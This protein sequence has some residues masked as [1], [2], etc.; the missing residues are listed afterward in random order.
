MGTALLTTLVW[1]V[2]VWLIVR[3]V[4]ALYRD[5]ITRQLV[6][7]TELLRQEFG[8]RLN[9]AHAAELDAQTKQIGT[10]RAA[11]IRVTLIAPDGTVLADSDA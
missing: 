9:R 10:I 3:Q 8:E 5:D 6:A 1:G 7:Y 2:L 4:E 11:G